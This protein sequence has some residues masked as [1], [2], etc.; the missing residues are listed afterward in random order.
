ML[1]CEKLGENLIVFKAT[2]RLKNKSTFYVKQKTGSL[3]TLFF[4]VDN[5]R[6][7]SII[8]YL[9]HFQ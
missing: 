4:S 5:L 8:S 2:K 1:F 3:L 9:L 7:K 6:K